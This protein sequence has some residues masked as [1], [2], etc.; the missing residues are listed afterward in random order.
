MTKQEIIDVIEGA[1]VANGTND[2][3]A[4]VLRPVLVSMVTQINDAVGSLSNLDT[5]IKDNIV[6][7]L[8]EVFNLPN[9]GGITILTGTTNPNTTAPPVVS[10]GDFYNRT[11]SGNTIE[12]YI[13]NG[14]TW[15]LL[16]N[17]QPSSIVSYGNTYRTTDLNILIPRSASVVIYQGSTESTIQ[18]PNSLIPDREITIINQSNYRLFTSQIY[19]TVTGSQSGLINRG[20]SITIKDDNQ[21]KWIQIR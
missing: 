15:V 20:M 12:F 8:N 18:I 6:N 3:T 9:G 14:S 11:F 1:I 19:D 17:V 13:F 4:D 16:I 5:T 7:A 2:I 10:L 21:I